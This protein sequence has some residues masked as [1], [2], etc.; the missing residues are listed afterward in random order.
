MADSPFGGLAGIGVS[1]ATGNFLG[2]AVGAVGLGLSLFGGMGA[3]HDAEQAA[4][5]QGQIAGLEGNV[6]EQRRSAMQLDSRRKSLEQIRLA[7]RTSAQAT[8][9]ATNQGAQFGSGLQGGLAQIEGQGAFNLAGINQNL[10]IGQ[11]IFDIN[12]QISGQKMALSK[13]QTSMATN[14]GISSLGG[15]IMQAAP[16]VQK[17]SQGFGQGIGGG[18]NIGGVSN[19]N[20]GNSIY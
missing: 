2:A 19:Y 5:I 17:A 4:Q 6:N 15:G 16:F 14:Q 1:A 20:S 10:E 7:Q 3:S 12:S 11:N 9:A 18:G 8:A 13:V